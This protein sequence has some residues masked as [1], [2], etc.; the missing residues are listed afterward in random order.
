LSRKA[1]WVLVST[2]RVTCVLNGMRTPAYVEDSL[3]VLG[4]TPLTEVRTVYETVKRLGRDES[5]S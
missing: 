1:L 2:P 5:H 3:A 4:W